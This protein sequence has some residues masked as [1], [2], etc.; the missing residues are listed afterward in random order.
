MYDH[1]NLVIMENNPK[2]EIWFAV[3]NVFAASKKAASLWEE[4]EP[5]PGT[6][7][8]YPTLQV[9]SLP[10]EAP[11]KPKYLSYSTS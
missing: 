8:R 10:S 9:D 6:E 5:N 7:P 4:A 3:V 2:N 11:G 1:N